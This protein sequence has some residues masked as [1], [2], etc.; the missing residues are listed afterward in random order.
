ME[1]VLTFTVG[2]TGSETITVGLSLDGNVSALS[3]ASYEQNIQYNFGTPE[4]YFEG[5]TGF[6]PPITGPTSGWLTSSFAGLTMSGF[7]F[8]GTL[9]VTNGEIVPIT[10][11]QQ[12]NCDVGA[13]CDFSD[14]TQLSLTLPS[15]VS[16]T[17]ASGVFLTQ[18][19]SGSPVPEPG[20]L[21]LMALA[22][23][24]AGWVAR[25]RSVG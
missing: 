2:G 24:A 12:M 23:V 14:T 19:S 17:S 6:S 3:P 25:R 22:I 8:T 4:V 13:V 20:S 9:T 10:F 21:S 15:D 11:I 7:N 1:D 5:G 16:Y 18:S